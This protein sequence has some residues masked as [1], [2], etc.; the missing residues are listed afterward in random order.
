MF[1]CLALGVAISHYVLG[2][3]SNIVSFVSPLVLASRD[4][5]WHG[6]LA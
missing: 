3:S 5:I 6:I 1:V 4:P 2:W